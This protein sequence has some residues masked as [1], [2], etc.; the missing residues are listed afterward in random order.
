MVGLI[1]VNRKRSVLVGILC[2][3]S[4]LDLWPRL[5]PWPW[6]SDMTVIVGLLDVK[7][8]QINWIPGWSCDLALWP[9]PRPCLR[10][11]LVQVMAW[12]DASM[13]LRQPWHPLWHNLKH[14]HYSACKKY[15]WI[16]YFT[17]FTSLG[18]QWVKMVH[19]IQQSEPISHVTRETVQGL[20]HECIYV[21]GK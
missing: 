8:K 6:N 18:R 19:H 21:M 1:D 3:F 10:P 16:F 20:D 5:W 13:F 4:D 2:R 7:R 9:F 12:Y 11:T 14:L 15:T 17:F